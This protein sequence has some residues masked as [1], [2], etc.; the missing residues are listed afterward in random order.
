MLTPD[1]RLAHEVCKQRGCNVS[2]LADNNLCKRHRDEQR[3]RVKRAMKRARGR[4]EVPQLA[5]F[6][7]R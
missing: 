4:M 1:T 2:A 3:K 5:L 6:T 7:I